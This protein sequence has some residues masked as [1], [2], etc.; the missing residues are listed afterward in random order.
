MSEAEITWVNSIFTLYSF[1]IYIFVFYF[2]FLVRIVI[3]RAFSVYERYLAIRK[4]S[5]ATTRTLGH[6]EEVEV[7]NYIN[8][9]VMLVFYFFFCVSF[10]FHGVN[11]L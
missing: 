7:S 3:V 8:Q 2:M 1:F 11:I 4:Y 9:G 10:I 6:G 5:G